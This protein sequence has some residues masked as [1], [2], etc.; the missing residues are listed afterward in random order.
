MTIGIAG[1]FSLMDPETA[2]KK[3]LVE[4]PE[5]E[6]NRLKAEYSNILSHCKQ[7]KKERPKGSRICPYCGYE[8]N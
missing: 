8:Y 3:I 7:C 2:A 5:L 6:R 4:H 1:G